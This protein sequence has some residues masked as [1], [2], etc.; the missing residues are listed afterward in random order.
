MS[1]KNQFDATRSGALADGHLR[2]AFLRASLQRGR[3]PAYS[4]MAASAIYADSPET[5]S[6]KSAAS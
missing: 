3:L 4:R 1:P 5:F 2:V 6:K